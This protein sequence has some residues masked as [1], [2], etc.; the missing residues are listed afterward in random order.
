[1]TL[2]IFIFVNLV[3]EK[4]VLKSKYR[5]IILIIALVFT[6]INNIIYHGSFLPT[7]L[8]LTLNTVKNKYN[9]TLRNG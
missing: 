2:V 5:E 9:Q 8:L 1:M 7:V 4:L 3:F 6:F